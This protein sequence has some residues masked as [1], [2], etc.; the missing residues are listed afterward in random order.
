MNNNLLLRRPN[1]RASV[2]VHLIDGGHLRQT[3]TIFKGCKEFKGAVLKE[4]QQLQA[5]DLAKRHVNDVET[6]KAEL[7]MKRVIIHVQ[8]V[9]QLHFTPSAL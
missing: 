1:V 8:N 7:C 3:Q 2:L 4:K 9:P 6:L 5:V